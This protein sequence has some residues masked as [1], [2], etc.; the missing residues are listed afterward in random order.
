[1]KDKIESKVN[2]KNKKASHE[3]HFLEL[4]TAGIVLQGTEIKSI[5]QSKVN[6]QDAFCAFKGEEIYVVNMHISTYTEGTHYNH[7]PKADRKLL[8][9]KREI[10][11][12]KKALDEK[13]LT[14]IPTRLYINEKGLAK[15]EIALAKGKKLFDKREDIKERDIKREIERER[16]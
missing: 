14:I 1:M 8:L 3:Y 15:M 2:L 11:K 16:Y 10:A 13:G 5:R 6:M 9:K 12:L 4:Y 7:V